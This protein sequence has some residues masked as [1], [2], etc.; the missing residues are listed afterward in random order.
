MKRLM[1]IFRGARRIEIFLALAAI[2]I[3][4]LQWGG[5]PTS[6]GMQTELESRLSA[7]L[8]QMDGVG[9]VHVMIAQD[10]TGSVEGVLVVADGA[11]DVGVR[12]RIQYALQT[13]LDA[14]ASDIEVVRNAK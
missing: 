2:A 14:E 8:S 6:G 7:I 3:L 12:L 13:L 1:E 4:L 9:K 11:D 10:E 5:T